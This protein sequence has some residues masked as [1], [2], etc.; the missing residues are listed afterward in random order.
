MLILLVEADKDRVTQVISN[1][2]SNAIKFTKEV[3]GSI[4]VNTEKEDN[5][6]LVSVKDTND[7]TLMNSNASLSTLP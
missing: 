4:S 6:I 2:L 7:N 5:H 1:L 3:R